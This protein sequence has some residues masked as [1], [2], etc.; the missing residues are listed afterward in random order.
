MAGLG[1]EALA[2]SDPVQDKK[3]VLTCERLVA[4]LVDAEGVW[5]SPLSI[6]SLRD[7]PM[8]ANT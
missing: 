5:V 6:A 8:S 1:V 3:V 2:Y 7:T 4:S